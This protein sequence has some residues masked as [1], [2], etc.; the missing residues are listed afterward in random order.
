MDDRNPV[1]KRHVFISQACANWNS[2]QTHLYVDLFQI[3]IQLRCSLQHLGKSPPWPF[4]WPKRLGSWTS[5]IPCKNTTSMQQNII[6]NLHISKPKDLEDNLHVWRKPPRCFNRTNHRAPLEPVLLALEAPHQ[7]GIFPRVKG[8]SCVFKLLYVDTSIY[9]LY[10]YI[11]IYHI[12]ISYI[13]ILYIVLP[14]SVLGA[15]EPISSPVVAWK[16]CSQKDASRNDLQGAKGSGNNCCMAYLIVK[17]GG[18]CIVSICN[19]FI[20]G[21]VSDMLALKI[22]PS[23]LLQ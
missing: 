17:I 11:Y 18:E 22:A 16:R 3:F 8:V 10:V 23:G 13:C 21:W 7:D 19:K 1:K 14:R 15:S 20:I 9:T 12:Y 4:I 6:N 5:Q 2:L